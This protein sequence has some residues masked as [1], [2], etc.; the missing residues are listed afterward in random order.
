MLRRAVTLAPTVLPAGLAEIAADEIGIELNALDAGA[1]VDSI[2][3]RVLGIAQ[4]IL[5]L[6]PADYTARARREVET[7]GWRPWSMEVAA[8]LLHLVD[9]WEGQ[10]PGPEAAVLL[11]Q[12]RQLVQD[13]SAVAGSEREPGSPQD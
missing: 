12:V 13:T 11:A 5:S 6:T 1:P 9:T 7:A 10:G 8:D 2:D 3:E 4:E